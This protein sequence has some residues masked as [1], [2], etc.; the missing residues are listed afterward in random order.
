MLVNFNLNNQI[1]DKGL[2]VKSFLKTYY[3]IIYNRTK[4]KYIHRPDKLTIE[5]KKNLL[6]HTFNF[7]RSYL[8][9]DEKIERNYYSRVY[10]PI[11]KLEKDVQNLS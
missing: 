9:T 11:K 10:K 3:E 4:T 8:D 5:E 7:R 6:I 2:E 1:S